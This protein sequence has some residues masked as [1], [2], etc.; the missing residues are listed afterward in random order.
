VSD[1]RILLNWNI[2]QQTVGV[3]IKLSLCIIKCHS[4]KRYGGVEAWLHTFLTLA[5][6]GG[7]WSGSCPGCFTLQERAPTQ[8]PLHR[9]LGGSQSQSGHDSK[10][11]ISLPLL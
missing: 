8:S 10:E 7:E 1:G 3:S 4:M 2:Q 5:L 9:N 11:K 6:D